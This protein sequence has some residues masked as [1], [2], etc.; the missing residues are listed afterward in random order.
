M[1]EALAVVD[2]FMNIFYGVGTLAKRHLLFYMG[3]KSREWYI[4]K[5]SY[6]PADSILYTIYIVHIKGLPTRIIGSAKLKSD[7]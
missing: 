2:W 3:A 6:F 7:N 4:S 5:Y 1:K